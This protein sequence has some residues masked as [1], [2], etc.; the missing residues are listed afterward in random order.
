MSTKPTVDEVG[1]EIADR[2]DEW[3]DILVDLIQIPSE[4]PP[5]DTREIA[6]YFTDLLD[7]RGVP[8]EVIS[9]Q[10]EMPNVLA[11]FD[12]G[13]GD[14]NEGPH[15]VFNGHLDT[16]PATG[17]DRWDYDPF[18]G[19]IDD[20]KVYGRG[21]S[22]MHGGF[23]GTLAAF[24]Y[25]FENKE[26]FSGKVTFAAVSDEETGGKWGTE[27]L[28]ENHTEYNGDVVLNGEPSTNGVIRFGERGPIWM[29]I[30]VRGQ[31]A[32]ISTL[33]EKV[34]A[35]EILADV[36]HDL[37]RRDD[38]SDRYEIPRKLKT[39]FATPRTRWMVHSAGAR[40]TAS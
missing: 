4:N 17:G 26:S 8:Y 3:L 22:D 31:A 5:N 35:V 24:F 32:H 10:E 36:I 39:P 1:Q 30:G 14:P 21:S 11:Q 40:P 23:T 34:N 19:E 7:D 16:F 28:V 15:V 12:G 29:E 13:I 25:L 33:E 9:P 27:Y 2:K 18:G 6:T 37:T 20:G 38:L